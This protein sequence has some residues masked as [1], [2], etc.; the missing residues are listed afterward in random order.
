MLFLEYETHKGQKRFSDDR[1]A[2][3]QE[4]ESYKGIGLRRPKSPSVFQVR[5]CTQT[6]S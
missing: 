4:H 3:M 6:I 5:V 1:S 2:Y